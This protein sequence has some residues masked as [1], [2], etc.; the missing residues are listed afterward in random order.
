MQLR[1][2]VESE[3]KMREEIDQ[4]RLVAMAEL[5]SKENEMAEMQRVLEERALQHRDA[6]QIQDQL[7]SQ[8]EKLNDPVQTEIVVQLKE[9]IKY[10]FLGVFC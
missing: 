5:Q 3:K 4:E 10:I 9:Q 1:S 7:E 8:L 6:R 2:S